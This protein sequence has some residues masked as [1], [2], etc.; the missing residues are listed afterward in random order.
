MAESGDVRLI[1]GRCEEVLPTLADASVD[2]VL[3][4]PPYP[5]I[6][7]SYGYWTEAEWFEMMRVVV[8]ECMRVLKPTGSAVFILQPNSERVGRMRTWL[9]EFIL[10]VG[11]EWGIVQDAWWWN[12]AA[13]TE[14]HSI[15][16][17]LM[18]PSIKAC[19]WIGANDCFRD[20]EIV[21]WTA[22]Q[23]TVA[24]LNSERFSNIKHP[25]GHHRNSASLKDALDRRGGV[26]PF[27]VLPVANTDSQTSA[28]AEGHGA[29]TPLKLADWWL[30]YLCPPGGICLDPFSGTATMGL[31]AVKQGKGYI[32]I[33]AIPDVLRHRPEAPGR[34]HRRS[35]PAAVRGHPN[36]AAGAATAAAL[37]RGGV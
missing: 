23:A 28:G 21:L 26:C 20:Q 32:G 15:Q 11:K 16:G 22:S 2:V 33:E 17:R 5:M 24:K 29:G 31:A 1:L 35:E 3:T 9:W 25:S 8:P 27:N 36:A 7:R 14:G 19:I 12:T 10:W 13:I 18:R 30:R 37:G 34:G 6:K 4:D